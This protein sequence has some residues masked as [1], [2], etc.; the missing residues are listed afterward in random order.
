MLPSDDIHPGLFGTSSFLSIFDIFYLY[1]L[2]IYIHAYMYI[3]IFTIHIGTYLCIYI[4]M[5]FAISFLYNTYMC[6]HIYI[7]IYTYAH[8]YFNPCW[9]HLKDIWN[10]YPIVPNIWEY[11]IL[12]C[13][14]K[15][16]IPFQ[17]VYPIV[18]S[19]LGDGWRTGYPRLRFVFP[20]AVE[21]TIA[22][23]VRSRFLSS[24]LKP[25]FTSRRREHR[26]RSGNDVRRTQFDQRQGDLGWD[27]F[28]EMLIPTSPQIHR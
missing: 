5:I 14:W 6:V 19:L 25:D 11:W 3:Y 15:K 17:E 7:Y 16:I 23:S 21:F 13:F 2:S 26:T 12:V 24:L 27:C 1:I 28:C 4:Y 10:N 9:G 22:Q 8:D 18:K 20:G